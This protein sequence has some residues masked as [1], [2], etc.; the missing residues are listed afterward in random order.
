VILLYACML[1]FTAVSELRIFFSSIGNPRLESRLVIWLCR[2]RLLQARPR[3]WRYMGRLYCDAD[4][5]TR[6]IAGGREHLWSV[7]V[8][9]WVLEWTSAAYE[10]ATWARGALLHVDHYAPH[11]S[12]FASFASQACSNSKDAIF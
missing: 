6:I 11:Q 10:T 4:E 2:C 5:G 1:Q 9:L 8:V 7:P 12:F 3:F